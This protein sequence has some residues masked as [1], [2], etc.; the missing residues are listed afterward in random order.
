MRMQAGPLASFRGGIA[1]SCG[2]GCRCG[3][4]HVF[5]WLWSRLAAVVSIRLLTWEPLYAMGVALKSKKIKNKKIK[6]QPLKKTWKLRGSHCGSVDTNLTSIHEDTGLIPGPAQWVKD[7][8]L[9]WAVVYVAD[10][11]QI[12][13]W[14]RLAAT[15]PIHPT[16]WELPH[17]VGVALKR[18]KQ[19]QTKALRS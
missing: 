3:S 10:M 18:K 12:W 15:A 14:Y 11:A 16:A 5:L 9:S 13:L 8:A 7:L 2:V 19:K 4:D 1:M 6:M 17:A